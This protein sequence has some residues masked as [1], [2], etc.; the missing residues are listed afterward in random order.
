VFEVYEEF[1]RC[2]ACG[3]VYWKGSHVERVLKNLAAL[4][5]EESA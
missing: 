4:L 2:A 3:H 1:F 5:G